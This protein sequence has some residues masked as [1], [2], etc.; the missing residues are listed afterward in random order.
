MFDRYFAF[1]ELNRF[2][3]VVATN[4]QSVAVAWLVY[5]VTGQPLSLGL[6]GLMQFIPM[7][8]LFPIAGWVTD[9][10]SRKW[11]LFLCQL[12]FLVAALTLYTISRTPITSV[13]P[14][15]LLLLGMGSMRAFMGPA[16]TTC[17]IDIV[18]EERYARVIPF[19][20]VVFEIATILGPTIGG[21]LYARTSPHTVFLASSVIFTVA[22]LSLAL[23]RVGHVARMASSNR[24]ISSI[25]LGVRYVAKQ[26]ILLGAFALD[27]FA[28]FF[29]GVVNLLPVFARDVLHTGA[30]GVGLMR[31]A[32]SVGAGLM[33]LYVAFNPIQRKNGRALF[34][35]IF[36]FGVTTV[37][38]AFSP[39]LYVSLALLAVLG[40]ADMVSVQVR[41]TTVQLAT[42]PAM[43]GRVAAVSGLFINASN[44]LGEFES[45]ATAQWWG[46]RAAAAVGG[47][48]TCGVVA[49]STKVFPELLAVDRFDEIRPKED[50]EAPLP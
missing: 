35:A 19:H 9:R 45:G 3:I 43:R 16:A 13:T 29:G 42:P 20:S 30:M 6:T 17:L 48:I 46:P 7:A 47:L 11:I 40:A 33:A 8:L 50:P 36:V 1:Y 26:K 44:E 32:P 25:L 27:L 18:G 41:M 31:S 4:I 2:L 24:G 10:F 15:Y 22:V 12:G 34:V 23:V 14:I 49:A 28:V 38:F 21:L 39:H 37:A 5:E